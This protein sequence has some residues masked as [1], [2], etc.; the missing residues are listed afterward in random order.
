MN[1]V[2]RE[3]APYA[4]HLSYVCSFRQLRP[5]FQPARAE[6]AVTH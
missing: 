5:I 2:L 3:D 4:Q 1:G 6:M